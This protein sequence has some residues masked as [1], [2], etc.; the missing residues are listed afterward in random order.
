MGGTNDPPTGEPRAARRSV[1]P[2]KYSTAP[3]SPMIT[4][5]VL[6]IEEMCVLSTS[7]RFCRNLSME[8]NKLSTI[9]PIFAKGSVEFEAA[10]TRTDMASASSTTFT[11]I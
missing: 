7:L 8:F 1:I 6:D 9:C 4:E 2:E 5:R 10:S 3:I 11:Y